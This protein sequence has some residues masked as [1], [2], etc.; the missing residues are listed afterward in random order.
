MDQVLCA[1]YQKIRRVEKIY[2]ESLLIKLNMSYENL[3]YDQEKQVI[4][5]VV[6]KAKF[7]QPL[8]PH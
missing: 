3:F 6:P 5:C 1:I 8:F 7:S 2:S 4:F